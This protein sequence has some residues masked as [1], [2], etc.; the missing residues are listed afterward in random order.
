MDAYICA[1]EGSLKLAA[2]KTRYNVHFFV[3]IIAYYK[4][5]NE[6]GVFDFY[7]WVCRAARDEGLFCNLNILIYNIN[8][9]G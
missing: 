1:E 2:Q 3:D 6:Y 4:Q 5:K 9:I 8:N 7:G